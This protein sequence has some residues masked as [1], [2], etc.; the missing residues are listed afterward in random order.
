ML[1]P[2]SLQ[3]FLGLAHLINRAD[4]ISQRITCDPQVVIKARQ[5]LAETGGADDRSMT[6][7]TAEWQV[8]ISRYLATA[9]DFELLAVEDSIVVDGKVIAGTRS[10]TVGKVL[11][12]LFMFVAGYALAVFCA[13]QGER[14]LIRRFAWQAAQA[15]VVS[16]WLL[17]LEFV[18]LLVIVL[19][20]L[21][22][23]D[24]KNHVTLPGVP[25]A[26][27][28][29]VLLALVLGALVFSFRNWRCPACDSYLGK[30]MSPRFC[31]KCGV[32][33]Q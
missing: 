9:W 24:E 28:A 3:K 14:L 26:V 17:A 29:P 27:V 10:V 33:L 5:V 30:G 18:L 11:T 13:R 21:F 15:G 23:T 20:F 25:K 7:R 19:A 1:L 16:R 31:P 8:R 6:E 4:A 22:L 12:A 2:Q 32:A